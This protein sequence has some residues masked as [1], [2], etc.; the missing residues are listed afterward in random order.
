MWAS[1]IARSHLLKDFVLF[2]LASLKDYVLEGVLVSHDDM[3]L[4]S[5]I[6]AFD[7]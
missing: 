4:L 1:V 3:C 2:Y 5:L 7:L 6:V